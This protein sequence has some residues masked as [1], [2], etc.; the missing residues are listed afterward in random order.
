[1]TKIFGISAPKLSKNN[2]TL[3]FSE[4]VPHYLYDLILTVFDCDFIWFNFYLDIVP[5][6]TIKKNSAIISDSLSC[7]FASNCQ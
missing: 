7:Q 1:M 4:L 2:C 6:N 3:I 5:Q